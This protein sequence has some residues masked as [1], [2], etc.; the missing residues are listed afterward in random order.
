MAGI[1]FWKTGNLGEIVAFYT[2][3][4]GMQV[5]LEQPD[6]TLLRHGNLV[7]GFV[8]SDAPETEGILTIYVPQKS[9]VDRLYG[10][11][12]SRALGPPKENEKY[13][14][15]NFFARDPEGRLVEFQAFRHP[16][17]HFPGSGEMLASR[18]SIRAFRDEPVPEDVVRA[19]L[20]TCRYSPTSM[21]AQS[22]YYVVVREASLLEKLAAARGANSAP[23][24]RAPC[25]VAVVGD[26]EV[27]GACRVDA[28][29]AATYFLLSAWVHGLGT[30][31]IGSMDREDV[32][33]EL[34]IPPGHFVSCVTPLGYP[35][36]RPQASERR[37]VEGMT[38]FLA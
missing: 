28:T 32:K 11:F 1:V 26:P 13:D 9:D 37:T 25:A 23:V 6:C 18:R 35:A 24:G 29:I 34:G 17:V 4:V 31:W 7:V 22:Y 8:G 33:Q 27:S 19:V 30:C 14:I 5:W 36:E 12:E 21:N 20:E 15:Y 38:R 10:K 16:V 3:E 2:R